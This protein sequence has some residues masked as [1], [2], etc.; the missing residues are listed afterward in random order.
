MRII[1]R[2]F[3]ILLLAVL[4]IYSFMIVDTLSL[5]SYV[6][7]VFRGKVPLG[8][9]ENTPERRYN[10]L[11]YFENNIMDGEIKFNIVRLFTWHNFKE[12]YIKVMYTTS[13]Y[14]KNGRILYGSHRIFSKWMIQKRNGKWVIIEIIE[15]P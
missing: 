9:T 8:H 5:M 3:G 15:A 7:D 12:G 4:T 11:S 1:I 13:A 14:D 6:K 10:H 2:L